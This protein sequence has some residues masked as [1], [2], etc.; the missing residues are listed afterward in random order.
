M[1][2][3]YP[4]DYQVQKFLEESYNKESIQRL[5]WYNK[6]KENSTAINASKQSEVARRKIQNAPKPAQDI[7]NKISG[8]YAPQKFNKKK[9]NYDDLMTKSEGGLPQLVAEMQPVEPRVKDKLFDGFTKEGKGRYQYLN[10]RYKESPEDKFSFPL[11]SSW[12]YGWRLGDVIKKEDIKKPQHGRTKIVA[13]TFY[14][15]TGIPSNPRVSV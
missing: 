14:T 2:R 12:E 5:A 3:N 6:R 11:L 15:R 1:A 10:C 9:S 13:D 4:A 7:F 8:G